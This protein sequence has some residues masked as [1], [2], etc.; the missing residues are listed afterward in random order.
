MLFPN[1]L[2][3]FYDYCVIVRSA[4]FLP[5]TPFP[6]Q[7]YYTIHVFLFSVAH[8]VFLRFFLLTSPAFFSC[9]LSL[10]VVFLFSLY[11]IPKFFVSVSFSFLFSFP[12]FFF[13]FSFFLFFFRLL[14]LRS[15]FFL[16]LHRRPF[17]FLHSL[18]LFPFL[19]PF[20]L[21]SSLQS[22]EA[23]PVSVTRA[24]RTQHTV[25]N[26]KGLN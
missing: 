15:I 25:G 4:L 17:F 26:I 19:L 12:L 6:R 2:I 18:L 23:H 24:P 20:F 7:H 9:P 22:S 3:V 5:V 13:S 16:Y 14:L 11:N 1:F 10:L 21:L 8:S